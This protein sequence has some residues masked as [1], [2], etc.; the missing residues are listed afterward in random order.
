M[1]CEE[2]RKKDATNQCGVREN[3]SYGVKISKG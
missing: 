1:K 2:V 3:Q